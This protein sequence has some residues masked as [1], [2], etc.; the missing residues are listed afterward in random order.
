MHSSRRFLKITDETLK[1]KADLEKANMSSILTSPKVFKARVKPKME[2][3]YTQE[4]KNK[5]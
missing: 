2:K 5:L 1:I 4:Q 3:G